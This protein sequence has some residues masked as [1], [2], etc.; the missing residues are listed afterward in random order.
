MGL[1]KTS[2]AIIL[3]CKYQIKAQGDESETF[4]CGKRLVNHEALILNGQT[5][6]EGDWPWHTGILHIQSNLN[7]EYKCGGTLINSQSVL[8]AAHCVYENSRPIVPDR[9]LIQLGRQNLKISATHSQDIEVIV[10][11]LVDSSSNRSVHLAFP[12]QVFQIFPH[13]NFNESSLANDIAIV[14]LATRATFNNYV[15]PICLWESNKKDLSEV[16]GKFGTVV[17]FGITE[18]DQISYTLRQAVIPVV[19]LTTCLESDRNFFGNFLSDSTFCAGYRNGNF[20]YA[21]M[22]QEIVIVELNV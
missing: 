20:L 12:K 2:L 7:I 22:L 9:V 17:G 10:T 4:S 8:T 18:T 14:R 1:L 5:S 6:K 21:F 19:D 3:L 11:S 15:Q 16:V 13:H